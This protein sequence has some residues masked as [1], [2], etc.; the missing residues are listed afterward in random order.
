MNLTIP[1]SEALRKLNPSVITIRG[2]V[3]Y[4]QE[5]NIIEY[6]LDEVN[7]K[8]EEMQAAENAAK[9]TALAKLAALGLTTADLTALGL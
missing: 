5:E 6:D 2:D 8:A 4:D 7:A 9:T 1:Q 3:A